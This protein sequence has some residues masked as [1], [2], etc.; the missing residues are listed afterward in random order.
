[1]LKKDHIWKWPAAA[2]TIFFGQLP[3]PWLHNFPLGNSPLISILLEQDSTLKKEL[4]VDQS[5]FHQ[6]LKQYW[7][8]SSLHSKYL[9]HSLQELYKQKPYLYFTCMRSTLTVTL[10]KN[11]SLK[12]IRWPLQLFY[13]VFLNSSLLIITSLSDSRIKPQFLFPHSA[14]I[15]PVIVILRCWFPQNMWQSSSQEAAVHSSVSNVPPTCCAG[16]YTNRST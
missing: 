3:G 1:M 15:L 8:F 9:K 2:G 11:N 12:L 16:C 6:L 13:E 5:I 7:H 4:W 14:C 10:L